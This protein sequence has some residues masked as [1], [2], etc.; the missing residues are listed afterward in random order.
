M[1]LNLVVGVDKIENSLVGGKV[2]TTQNTLESLNSDS[3]LFYLQE[4]G[5]LLFLFS[6]DT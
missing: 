6:E 4:V 3:S 1:K 5:C 2:L